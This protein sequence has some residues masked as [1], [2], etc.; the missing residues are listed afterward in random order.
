MNNCSIGFEKKADLSMANELPTI[1][2]HVYYPA[3][4]I[5]MRS[6]QVFDRHMDDRLTEFDRRF[7]RPRENP[8]AVNAS[9]RKSW[10]SPSR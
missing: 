3:V 4:T 2:S 1:Q 5:D 7:Y 8:V 6:W 9:E 10:T